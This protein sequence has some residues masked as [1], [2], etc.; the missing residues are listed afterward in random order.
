MAYEAPLKELQFVIKEL[1]ELD[2]ISQLPG[3]EDA[4]ADTVDIILE[5]AGK[6]A[7]EKLSAINKIG[8][9]QGAVWENGHVSTPP[10]W[11][12]TY[13]ELIEAGWNSPTANPEHGGMGLPKLVNMCI[14]EMFQ[15]ANMAFQ[16]CPLLTQGAI[17]ALEAY[18]SDELKETYLANLVTGK[19]TGTM[20]LTEPQAG[21]D[22]AAIGSTATPHGDHFRIR[23]QKIFITYGDHDM[24]E[25]IIHLVLARLPDAPEGVKGIS[26]FVV[27]KFLLN[28]DGSIGNR[29]DVNCV[30]IEHKL[31]IHGSPTCTLAFGDNDGAI[32]YLIGEEHCGLRYMFT[33]MND[34]RLSVG[35]QSI[36]VGE[37]AYQ[38]AMR[39]AQERRQGGTNNIIEYPDIRRMLGEMRAR[40]DAA[41]IL[42]LRTAAALDFAKCSDDPKVRARYQRRADLFIPIVKAFSTEQACKITSLGIQVFGG[43]GY[44]EETGVAQHFRDVRIT[45]IYEGTTGI[46]ALDLIGRKLVMDKGF[47]V[48]ELIRDMKTSLMSIDRSLGHNLNW[49]AMCTMLEE[50]IELLET[51]TA[52]HIDKAA[53]NPEISHA[54]AVKTLELFGLS[55]GAWAMFDAA[56]A[57]AKQLNLTND[58]EFLMPKLK[59]SEF[60]CHQIFPQAAAAMRT[61]SA[62]S[63]SILALSPN[64]L[65]KS[66]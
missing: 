52:W 25:N 35:V 22:L 7:S 56:V 11:R 2:R 32:G 27:P 33:M 36:G 39:F 24:T 53:S 10:E 9:T 46:Q 41:R 23:G 1:C 50:A 45:P 31:G 55:M 38:D 13:N 61:I 62:G 30:S 47:A 5:E 15:G 44:I 18:A 16:L 20:N 29:N 66:R 19:W 17:E 60:Y 42:A 6:F 28:D 59:I 63:D 3:F 57:T 12:K 26:L 37:H 51:V 54:A 48:N 40:T 8:D 64:D 65:S 43:M 4:S 21:S 14:Q 58:M 34:A 49:A